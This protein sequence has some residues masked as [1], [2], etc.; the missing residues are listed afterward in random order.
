MLGTICPIPL[1]ALMAVSRLC[2]DDHRIDKL[3]LGVGVY[4]N[5][6]GSTPVMEVV[7]TAEQRILTTQETKAYLGPEGDLEFADLLCRHVLGEGLASALGERIAAVQALG[8]TGAFR[9]AAEL[10]SRARR[11]PRAWVGLPTWPNHLPILL[12]AGLEV[13]TYTYYDVASA[14]MRFNDMAKALGDAERG[15]LVVLHGCCHNSTGA[16]LDSEQWKAVGDIIVRRGL[17]PLVDFAYHG[18]GRGIDADAAGVRGLLARVPEAL[19]AVSCSK[20]FGLY[21]ER[22]GLLIALGG[23]ASGVGAMRN[24]MAGIARIHYSG[25]ADHGAAIVRT[26]LSDPELRGRWLAGLE[27]MR[28]RIARVRAALATAA[29]RQG[30]DLD[31]IVGQHG[32][33]SMLP[34]SPEDV[35]QLRRNHAVYMPESGRVNIAGLS[36]SSVTRF[37]E[38]LLAATSIGNAERRGAP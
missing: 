13:A 20:T 29:A 33:F 31:F 27:A 37:V 5:D 3:D 2:R 26:V 28:E 14:Q 7:K 36:E 9:L 19:V 34:I 21:R 35:D 10:A 17:V 38:A 22:T 6:A 11:K 12:D 15:D 1:D 25:P 18:F 8:G 23:S 32:L 4:R 16:D 24:T 30:L